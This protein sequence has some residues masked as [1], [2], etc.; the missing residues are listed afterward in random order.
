MFLLSFF[1]FLPLI[2]CHLA[3]YIVQAIDIPQAEYEALEDL[4]HST[5]GINWNWHTLSSNDGAVWNF[6]SPA[7]NPC[8]DKWSGIECNCTAM[9]CNVAGLYLAHYNM[10]GT[11]PTTFGNLTHLSFFDFSVNGVRGSL[12]ST[13]GNLKS[14]EK[15]T[16]F[17]NKLTGTLPHEI[18][19]LQQL[20]KMSL[21]ANN[22]HGAL[23]NSLYSLTRLFYLS[24]WSNNLSG[25]LSNSIGNLINL[26]YLYL[27]E[28]RL[29]GTLPASIGNL[30]ALEEID[31]GNNSFTVL[32]RTALPIL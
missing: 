6:S 27:D 23:P 2:L 24:L 1:L 30:T 15:M 21:E 16:F 11:L 29:N 18:G 20:T 22:L 28:N 10:T 19:N 7:A 9:S 3:L 25:T 14:L 13:I 31:F 5:H 12:P 32:F 4:Y 26:K 17:E 8:A